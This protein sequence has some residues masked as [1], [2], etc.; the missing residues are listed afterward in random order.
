MLFKIST[1]TKWQLRNVC[2]DVYMF[3]YQDSHTKQN[4]RMFWMDLLM[5]IRT[6]RVHGSGQ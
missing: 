3:H 1:N 6:I 4:S 2:L 5:N